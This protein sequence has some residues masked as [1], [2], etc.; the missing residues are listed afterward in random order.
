MRFRR[1]R[2]RNLAWML[3]GAGVFWFLAHVVDGMTIIA[4]LL[5]ILG[6]Y[7][8]RGYNDPKRGYLLAGAGFVLLIVHHLMLVMAIGLMLLGYFFT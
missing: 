3:I 7:R 2:H 6:I 8:A 1:L 4:L 5:L